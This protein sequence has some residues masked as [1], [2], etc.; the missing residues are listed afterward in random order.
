MLGTGKLLE[1]YA[2]IGEGDV[3][4]VFASNVQLNENRKKAKL[5]GGDSLLGVSDKNESE[6]SSIK[7]QK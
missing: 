3:L 7:T 4:T 2:W 6:L 5:M 1:L